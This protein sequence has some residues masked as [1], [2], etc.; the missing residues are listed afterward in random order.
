M[1]IA[2]RRNPIGHAVVL[3][4]VAAL[5]VTAGLVVSW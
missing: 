5:I 4:A 2:R 3:L 1:M